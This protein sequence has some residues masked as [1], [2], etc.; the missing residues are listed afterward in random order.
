MQRL[1][2]H[3]RLMEQQSTEVGAI[4]FK[5][6]ATTALWLGLRLADPS[7]ELLNPNLHGAIW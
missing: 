3:Y 5:R 6:L 2:Q 4:L 7:A 1:H